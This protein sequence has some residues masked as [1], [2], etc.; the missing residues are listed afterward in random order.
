MTHTSIAAVAA[1]FVGED[2]SVS[3]HVFSAG[4]VA[5]HDVD[6]VG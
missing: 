4:L 2:K 6:H 1:A 5:L 3:P